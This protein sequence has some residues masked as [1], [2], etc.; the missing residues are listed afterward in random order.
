MWKQGKGIKL[1]CKPF[2]LIASSLS[3][4]KRERKRLVEKTIVKKDS[5]LKEYWAK[6]IG[7]L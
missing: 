6:G 7:R 1:K 3:S 4:Q 5:P 2:D